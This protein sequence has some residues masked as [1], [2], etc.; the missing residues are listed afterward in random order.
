MISI[1]ILTLNEERVLPQTLVGM[2]SQR[3]A[4]MNACATP[5]S[6]AYGK[7]LLLLYADTRLPRG[8]LE[9]IAPLLPSAEAGAFQRA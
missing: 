6:C 3:V 1:V 4:Q 8:A 7:W 2:A 9:T 5:A